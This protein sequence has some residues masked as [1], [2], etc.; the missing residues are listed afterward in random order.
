MATPTAEPAL[1][2]K[3]TQ[4]K[5]LP[6]SSDEWDEIEDFV[7]GYAKFRKGEKWGI[8]DE[9][10]KIILK[11]R[12]DPREVWAWETSKLAWYENKGWNIRDQKSG[13]TK[14]LD[15]DF[16]WLGKSSVGLAWFETKAKKYGYINLSGEIVI[17]A[18]WDSIR[19]FEPSGLAATGKADRTWGVIDKTGREVVPCVYDG[20]TFEG[21]CIVVHRGDK[22]G[23]FDRSGKEL[24]PPTTYSLLREGR[25][26][27]ILTTLA[28]GGTMANQSGLMD[29]TTGVTIPAEWDEVMTLGH[30]MALLVPW[31]KDKPKSLYDRRTGKLT[32]TSW[33]W[34][35]AFSE[36]MAAVRESSGDE[37]WGFIDSSGALVIR[38]EWGQVKP[39]QDGVAFVTKEKIQYT[40]LRAEGRMFILK[41]RN[42][43]A[44]PEDGPDGK[45]PES[46][47][48][49]TGQYELIDKTGRKLNEQTLTAA[50]AFQNGTAEV[51]MDGLWGTM[52]AR[53]R[54]TRKPSDFRLTF[55]SMAKAAATKDTLEVPCSLI[56]GTIAAGDTIEFITFQKGAGRP[57][58][59]TAVVDVIRKAFSDRPAL[60]QARADKSDSSFVL[61][62]HSSDGLALTPH[63]LPTHRGDDELSAV[64]AQPGALMPSMKFSGTIEW[65]V[66]RKLPTSIRGSVTVRPGLADIA[67]N[68]G[69]EEIARIE[70]DPG[71]LQARKGASGKVTVI[72]SSPVLLEKQGQEVGLLRDLPNKAK[73]DLG[74]VTSEVL[75]I[76][77]IEKITPLGEP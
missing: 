49:D 45:M 77:K 13:E 43:F 65:A 16:D 53:G 17:P 8:L 25:D 44:G 1:A 76:L 26:G 29:L 28:P 32:N 61:Q 47:D 30:G 23:L 18:I 72:T 55:N 59:R 42:S 37:N 14:R 41:D 74:D 57:Q 58:R 51:K 19:S 73:A 66:T 15:E 56:R 2:S 34:I 7:D 12:H 20:I 68:G 27:L 69:N 35:E 9:Q 5:K 31:D 22:Q 40:G 24:V 67:L 63:E 62:I 10:G 60:K 52:D 50:F 21:P 70:I 6:P 64:A 36:G 75:G 3:P 11:A 33:S 46:L 4:A 48:D 38:P 71:S 54:F 39:F